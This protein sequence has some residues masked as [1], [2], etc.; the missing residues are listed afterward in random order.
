MVMGMK[1][2]FLVD[3]L[4]IPMWVKLS[5]AVIRFHLSVVTFEK[6]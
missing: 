3:V 6:L 2:I 5:K 4:V 1:V